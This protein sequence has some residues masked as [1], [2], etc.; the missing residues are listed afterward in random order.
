MLEHVASP[1]HHLVTP[2]PLL[3][4]APQLVLHQHQAAH[5]LGW[6]RAVTPACLVSRL[7]SV[8][9]QQLQQFLDGQLYLEQALGSHPALLPHQ[10]SAHQLVLALGQHQVQALQGFSHLLLPFLG[11]PHLR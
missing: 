7:H 1:A 6:P 3:A 4:G 9:E 11:P 10:H 2:L 8:Q 5:Y